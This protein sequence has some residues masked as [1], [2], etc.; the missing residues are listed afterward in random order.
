MPETP[1]NFGE[2]R[3]PKHCWHWSRPHG[4]EAERYCCWCGRVGLA[5]PNGNIEGH[6]PLLLKYGADANDAEFVA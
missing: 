2:P 6:G 1:C 3:D 4:V 5:V